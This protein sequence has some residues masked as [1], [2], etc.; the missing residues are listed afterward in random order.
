MPKIEV[1]RGE[2]LRM[3]RHRIRDQ[4]GNA[5]LQ[6]EA[7]KIVGVHMNTLTAYETGKI[8]CPDADFEKIVSAY[9]AYE[10]AQK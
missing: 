6:E 4:R 10:A 9:A 3:L 8:P 5:L 7:Y 2:Y 1:T